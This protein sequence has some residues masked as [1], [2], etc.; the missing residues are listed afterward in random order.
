M[1]GVI[2][3]KTKQILCNQDEDTVR[4][5]MGMKSIQNRFTDGWY[6]VVPLFFTTYVRFQIYLP[7]SHVGCELLHDP[8]DKEVGDVDL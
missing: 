8:P 5:N 1:K 6:S 3:E 7:F 2:Y 4:R